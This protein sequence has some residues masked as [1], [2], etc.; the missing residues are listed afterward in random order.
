MWWAHILPK[1]NVDWEFKDHFFIRTSA[2]TPLK[3]RFSQA[4]LDVPGSRVV[5]AIRSA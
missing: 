1:A 5:D 4:H 2:Y 3:P